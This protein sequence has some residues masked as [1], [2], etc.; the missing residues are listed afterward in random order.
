MPVAA[1]LVV[2]VVS[3]YQVTFSDSSRTLSPCTAET[4]TKQVLRWLVRFVPSVVGLEIRWRILYL[5]L[6]CSH[7]IPS[8]LFVSYLRPTDLVPVMS[9]TLIDSQVGLTFCSPQQEVEFVAES[10]L[11]NL[12][13]L[14]K[15]W[16]CR[17]PAIRLAHIAVSRKERKLARY[18]CS[19]KCKT[20]CMSLPTKLHNTN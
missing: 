8:V 4:E 14:R 19:E 15:L 12:E 18:C 11:R 3:A 16:M 2:S 13:T 9:L 7:G 6:D 10:L 1:L 20:F 5:L 17:R